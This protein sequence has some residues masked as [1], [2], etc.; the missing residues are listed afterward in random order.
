MSKTPT[1][2]EATSLYECV[3]A[4]LRE[5]TVNPFADYQRDP[6]I[7]SLPE[8]ILHK[9]FNSV[10]SPIDQVCLLLACKKFHNT[11]VSTGVLNRREFAFPRL[12]SRPH[13]DPQPR[14]SDPANATTTTIETSSRTTLLIRLED[15]R[16][17]YCAACLHLHPKREFSW[18]ERGKPPL[19]RRCMPNAG[20]ID[21]CPCFSLTFRDRNKI[22]EYLRKV[23]A[24]YEPNLQGLDLRGGLRGSRR[25]PRPPTETFQISI[26]KN[27]DT[28]IWHQCRVLDKPGI[29]VDF[30]MG[31]LTSGKGCERQRLVAGESVAMIGR[32]VIQGNV[33]DCDKSLKL[34]PWPNLELLEHVRARREMVLMPCGARI[35]APNFN[36]GDSGDEYVV[37]NFYRPLGKVNWPADNVWAR[38]CR[39][40]HGDYR[41]EDE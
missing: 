12:K 24:K 8:A 18:F 34:F 2:P 37:V 9:I 3:C 28:G 1:K 25:E 19:E 38:H 10:P 5:V 16:W 22:A 23:A 11:F 27:G 4:F 32:Y 35:H 14:G 20:I 6:A 40:E 13:A 29:I 39:I 17:K 21:L 33:S 30:T 26:D 7:L 15:N 36:R 41:V 31:L